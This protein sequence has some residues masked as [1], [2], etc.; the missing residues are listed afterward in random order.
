MQDM[1]Q[2]FKALSDTTRLR[3][4]GLLLEG[5]LCVCDLMSILELPQSTVSRH[6]S[7]LRNAGLVEGRR[8]GVWM[9]YRTVSDGDGLGTEV[10]ELLR[11]NLLL[12]PQAGDDQRRLKRHQKDERRQA[13]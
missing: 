12:V 2:I 8:D 4:M 9:H 5:E 3:I 1:A 13:C 10:T 11:N 6:L 7:Y